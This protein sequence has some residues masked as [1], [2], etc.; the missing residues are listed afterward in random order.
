MRHNESRHGVCTNGPMSPF[1]RTPPACCAEMKAR[2]AAKI[3]ELRQALLAA[4]YESLDS[5]SKALGLSRSTTWSILNSH[6]KH[7]GL[8][9]LVI[10]RMLA[11]P[12]L[13]HPVRDKIHEYIEEKITGAYGHNAKMRRSFETKLTAYNFSA[14]RQQKS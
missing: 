3:R 5:Q 1:D 2:Q 10:V 11:A 14:K 9:A 13:P 7:S 8:S 12:Q 4:G 6:H